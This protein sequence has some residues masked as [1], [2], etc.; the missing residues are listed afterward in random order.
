MQADHFGRLLG[1]NEVT[2]DRVSHHRAQFINGVR[3]RGDAVAER[4]G[5]ITAFFGFGHLEDDFGTHAKI[6]PEVVGTVKSRL[7]ARL[8]ALDSVTTADITLIRRLITDSRNL[9]FDAEGKVS[10]LG[11]ATGR[12][13]GSG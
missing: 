7:S 5:A 2:T 6:I 1:V 9:L 4:R 11:F 12:S 8:A 13:S 3:L 10:L